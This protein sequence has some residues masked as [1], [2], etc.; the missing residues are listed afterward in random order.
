MIKNINS[1]ENRGIFGN[2]K[3]DA[4][5]QSFNKYNIFYGLN[6]SGKSTLS[7]LFRDI[8]LKKVSD[9]FPNSKWEID[10][11]EGKITEANINEHKLN[12]RVFNNE[13]VKTNIFTPNGVKGIVYISE[14]DVAAKDIL[15][16]KNNELDIQ[17][18][19]HN[20]VI[21]A[22][23]GD[24]QDRKIKGLKVENEYFLTSAA[25]KIKDQ[26]V[27]IK[28]TDNRLL[29][30]DKSKLRSFIAQNES[31]IKEKKG[32]LSVE[33][34]EFLSQSI[35][36]Q[37]KNKINTDNIRSINTE[38]LQKVYG[39]VL[40]LVNTSITSKCIQKL[41]DNPS[42]AQ[43]VYNGL[44]SFHKDSKIC[45]FCGQP[46]PEARINDL[47]SHFNDEFEKFQTAIGNGIEWLEQH[48][49]VSTFPNG[50]ELYDEFIK[51][52]DIKRAEYELSIKEVNKII[53]N[54]KE[55]L[56]K[57]RAHPFKTL[58]DEVPNLKEES[59]RVYQKAYD[60][61][62]AVINKH[63]EKYDNFER[64]IQKAKEQ[65]ELHY[66]IN[67][68]ISYDYFKKKQ[69]EASLSKDFNS[70]GYEID[71]LKIS[72]EEIQ[73]KLSDEKLG[74]QEFN[75]KLHNFLGRNDLSLV[76]QNDGSYAI[77]RVNDDGVV[78]DNTLSEGEKTA[79]GLIYFITKLQENGNKIED[80]II[81]LDDPV[82]SFD[83]DHLFHANY[84]IEQECERANQLIVF[85][86]NFKFFTLLKFWITNKN[87]KDEHNKNVPLYNMYIV[88]PYI[89]ADRRCGNIEPC[90][91][92]LQYFDSEYHWLFNE[93]YQYVKQPKTD[94]AN[95]H[96]I[97]N[98][99]RQLL[100]SFFSFKYGRKKLDKCFND[101]TGFNDL[102][103]VQKFVN[104]YSH[105]IDFGN[106][107]K[108]F[109]ENLMSEPEKIVPLVLDLIKYVD[110]VHYSSMIDRIENR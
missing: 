28:T 107:L 48:V 40:E 77:S 79:I 109:N 89:N 66:V 106:S 51:E 27:F 87:T 73:S 43:W 56:E 35:R 96:T 3:K 90:S 54:W 93:V 68:V 82:S 34:I 61:V 17:R 102:H 88:K 44:I 42:L 38:L 52:Y 50:N 101:V 2:Y 16:K 75:D 55:C 1:L 63:N 108:G 104:Y 53:Y 85:T 9:S 97:A 7:S 65:L 100:E 19:K 60:D 70:I 23:Y 36:P 10:T 30:Y 41:Q 5:L 81:V 14:K 26:F 39:R 13:F 8:E 15:D 24:P 92:V 67:E 62:L 74:E 21:K 49:V 6:G 29:N 99:S 22:L 69:Q 47:N 86:H 46:L 20:E 95:T 32:L 58:E 64:V 78:N 31:V 25:K 71:A 33:N 103:K 105:K 76:H 57:K 4:S 80:T 11:D 45:E 18:K 84:Y 110:P 98:I 91:N 83:S 37:N 12:I 59:Y 94:Y 72:I